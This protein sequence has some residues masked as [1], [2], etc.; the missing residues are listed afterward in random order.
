MARLGNVFSCDSHSLKHSNLPEQ[1]L[2]FRVSPVVKV[3]D[4]DDVK[5]TTAAAAI[6]GFD[7]T[8]SCQSVP[9]TYR[10]TNFGN[11][12]SGT[13]CHFWSLRPILVE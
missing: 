3:F 10:L 9:N 8:Y 6:E 4:I 5:A 12:L 7:G 1:L 13:A 11:P 2:D